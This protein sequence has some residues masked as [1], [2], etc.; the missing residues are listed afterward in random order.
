MAYEK[1]LT[2]V[3][4]KIMRE[5]K[6]AEEHE[7]PELPDREVAPEVERLFQVYGYIP[8]DES[9]EAV[10]AHLDGYGVL[11]TGPAGVGKTFLMKCLG[12]RI[13]TSVG[14]AAYGIK[15]LADF[16]EATRLGPIC[17][18]DLGIEPIVSEWGAK[19]DVLK[20]F[21]AYRAERVQARTHITTNLSSEEITARYG[22]R[23]LSRIMG[24]CKAFRLSGTN[25]REP[26]R[27]ERV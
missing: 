1:P 22:D 14:I 18:D 8:C 12:V 6:S 9:V 27:E 11:L 3:L 23:T 2:D 13:Y 25:R 24:M 10:R 16:H 5:V 26:K 21:I 19:D 15:G 4:A 17:I 7:R 20:T